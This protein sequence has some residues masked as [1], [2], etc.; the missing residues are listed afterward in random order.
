ATA[1][2]TNTTMKVRMISMIKACESIPEGVI[3]PKWSIGCSS[4]FRANDV[5]M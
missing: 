4:V 3:V 2:V 1:E 5:A